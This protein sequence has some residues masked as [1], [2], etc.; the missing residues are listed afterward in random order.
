MQTC[1]EPILV[2]VDPPSSSD[3]AREMWRAIGGIADHCSHARA[4]RPGLA[5]R[6]ERL[7]VAWRSFA[8]DQSGS[9]K[10]QYA[11]GA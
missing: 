8:V 3:S 4:P 10:T 6:G 9:L 7:L 11:T 1:N 2:V 5:A